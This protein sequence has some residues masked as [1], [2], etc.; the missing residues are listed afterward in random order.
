M[1]ISQS[2]LAAIIVIVTFV[3]YIIEVFPISITTLIGLLAMV[4]SGILTPSEA[5]S[6]FTG[7]AVFLTLGMII[8]V[9]GLF[10]SGVIGQLEGTLSKIKN[11]K[12]FTIG[13]FVLA[14]L[15]S[16]FIVNSALVAML[17]PFVTSVAAS[18]NGKI[19]KKNVYLTMASGVLIG[20]TG[21]MVGCTSPLMASS[22]LEKAGA[23]PLQFFSTLPVTLAIIAVVAL[24]QHLFLYDYQVKCFDFQEADNQQVRDMSIPLNPKKAVISTVVFLACAV[25]FMIRPFG[26]D[27]GQIAITGAVILV[28]TGCVD[29]KKALREM[30]WGTLITLGGAL[31]IAAGFEAS[32]AGDV[33][34]DW[35]IK[36]LGSWGSVP[37]VLM[38]VFLV[39]AYILSLVLPD[40]SLVLMLTTMGASLAI[41]E[42]CDP[43]V[44]AMACVFGS[45]LAFATPVATT[46]TTM[47]QIVGYRFK[48]YAKVGGTISLIGLVVAWIMIALLY[49]LF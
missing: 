34:V 17:M 8:I 32:G 46:T 42:G 19:K 6:G 33:A 36:T 23:A 2:T 31:G 47:V 14:A 4:Y 24:C 21:S 35:I 7:T 45:S 13:L 16:V 29:G 10:E 37:L 18:S 49:G 11:E 5:F 25:L 20:G 15:M 1:S 9:D 44:I 38:T 27:L 40:G 30:H 28:V 26:W 41:Q 22:A 12:R 43:Q 3:L 39:M 48:D